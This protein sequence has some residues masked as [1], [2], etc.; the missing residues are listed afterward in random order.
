M[1]KYPDLK[2]YLQANYIELFTSEIQKFVVGNYDGNGFHS[3]NVLSLLKHKI[4]N[5]EVKALTCHDDIGPRV[6][7]DVGLSADIVD[8]G[9]GTKEYE[10][11]RK[12]R[13]FKVF[14]Q[15]NL[16]DGF[17][18]VEVIDTKEYFGTFDKD[19]ALDQFLLPYIYKADF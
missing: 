11:D 2:S 17:R 4:E 14:I 16:I 9:L 3:I 10:A 8:M 5:V 7:M 6:K 19:N 18:D 13:W 1:A 12:T 15:G